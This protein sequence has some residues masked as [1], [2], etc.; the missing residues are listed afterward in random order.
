M[1]KNKALL[2]GDKIS[3]SYKQVEEKVG[4]KNMTKFLNFMNGQTCCLRSDGSIGYYPY[5][6]DK[7][8]QLI[9]E[10]RHIKWWEWD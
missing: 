4:K 3:L 9:K 1:K 7:F 8:C 10:K 5:D 2:E 6:V